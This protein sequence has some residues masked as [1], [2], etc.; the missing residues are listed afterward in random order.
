MEHLIL[1][2]HVTCHCNSV[3]C[4]HV[5]TC[6]CLFS[7]L[8]WKHPLLL[9]QTVGGRGD[10]GG[11]QSLTKTPCGRQNLGSLSPHWV[12]RRGGGRCTVS[13]EGPCLVGS[14]AWT[15][16]GCCISTERTSACSYFGRMMLLRSLKTQDKFGEFSCSCFLCSVLLL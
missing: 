9:P 6:S 3:S 16:M 7:L 15:R 10:I 8:D 2:L 14:A 4:V 5:V 12:G 11:A 1:F 13:F